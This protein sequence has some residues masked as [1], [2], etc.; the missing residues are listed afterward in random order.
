MAHRAAWRFIHQS[1][2]W[3][4]TGATC[5]QAQDKIPSSGSQLHEPQSPPCHAVPDLFSHDNAKL[6]SAPRSKVSGMA[7]YICF[8]SPLSV[9]TIRFQ[10]RDSVL[11]VKNRDCNNWPCPFSVI[12][13]PFLGSNSPLT[14]VVSGI[15]RLWP[16]NSFSGDSGIK[17]GDG[18]RLPV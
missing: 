14:L 8:F 6:D 18:K 15:D 1:T 16:F 9:S 4:V 13:R 11:A 17:G 12:P 3:C 7:Q 2:N 5:L 10:Q